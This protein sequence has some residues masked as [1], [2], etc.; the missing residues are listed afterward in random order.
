[1]ANTRI[2]TLEFLPEIFQT[3]TNA[4]FLSA[5][6]DQLVNPPIIQKIEGYIGSKLGYG[7]NAK[8][9]YVKEINKTR[10]DYQLDPGVVFTKN[11]ESVAQDFISYPG[12]LDAIK[13]EGGVV[14]NNNR[15]FESQF[16]SWDSFT[17]LDKLINY[18]QYY[19]IPNGPPSVTVAADVV[20][21]TND[22][23]V[24]DLSNGYNIR[25]V[26]ASGGSINPTLTLLRGGIYRFF[27]NQ[28]SQFWIQ[29]EPS[30]NGYSPTQTNL[31]VREVYGVANNGS[32][33]GIV[34]FV[35]PQKN[36]Q[37]EY[38]F[39]GN[40]LVD[41][42]STK[43]YSEINGQRLVDLVDIDGVTSL[44]GLTVM[45]YNT[46]ELDE[47]GFTQEFFDE[48]FYD[49]NGNLVLPQTITVT[50]TNVSNAITCN[51]TANLTVGQTI[52]FDGLSFGGL[53][54]YASTGTIYYVKTII[55]STQFTVSTELD[56][57]TVSLI[58]ASGTLI[59]N[60]NQG[61][62]EE[63]F[64][65][66]VNNFFYRVEYVGNPDNPV[67]KLVPVELIPT[68]EKI[69]AQYGTQWINRN[70]YK[71]IL[72]TISLMPYI[73]APLDTLYYQDG[74]N[75]NK[76]G[77]IRL[78]ESNFTNTLNVE[79]DILGKP[80]FTSTNGVVF[81][82]GLKVSFD[83]DVIPTS[84]LQG[85]YYVEG[86]GSAIELIPT[87]DLFCP[88]PFTEAEY[89]SYDA[90]PY[91]IGNYDGNLYIPVLQDYITIARNSISKNAWSR[92][93]RWFHIDVINATANY[94]NNPQIATTLATRQN[95]AKRPIIE[96]YPNLALFNTGTEGKKAIDFIDF[97]TTD[98]FSNVQGQVSYYPDVETY[99]TF[100]G[101]IN[102]VVTG[103]ST[104]ATIANNKIT[105]TFQVGQYITDT[106]VSNTDITYPTVLPP[107]ARITNIITNT[108]TTT[109]VIGWA[110]PI[111]I[112]TN[113][114]NVSFVAN[115]EQN[116]S[117]KVFDGSRI[118]FANDANPDVK[119]KIY[120]VNISQTETDLLP[121]ITLTEEPDAFC[122]PN[123]MTVVIRGFNYLGK[124][125]YFNG[126][127]WVVAQQKIYVNQPPLFDVFDQNYVSFG[128]EEVYQGTTFTGC[129]LFAYGILDGGVDDPILDFPI[130]YSNISNLGDIS[131]DVSINLDTFKYVSGTEP[132]TQKVNTGYVSN[133]SSRDSFVREIGWQTARGP[134]VQYQ[135]FSFDY[136]VE[137]PPTNYTCDISMLPY[138]GVWPTIQ[139]YI[140]NVFQPA[141][142]YNVTV[143]PKS[144]IVK[145]NTI[146]NINTVVQVLILS[147]QVS[148]TAYYQIPIN[149]SNNPFNDD[150]MIADLGDIR[151]HYQSIFY[152][153]L[154][155]VGE[156]FGANN[157]RDLGNVVPYGN[158]IIQNSASIVL[159]GAF[160][161]KQNHNLFDALLFNSREYT[162]FKALLINT[163]SN[164]NLPQQYNPSLVLD[165]ALDIISTSKNE[166]LAFFWSDMLPNKAP[167]ISN[168]Y[169]FNNTLSVSRFPLSR[170]Y[171]FDKANYYG[172]LV[173]LARVITGTVV[174]KQ[175]T[176]GVDYTV[177]G[178]TLIV[179]IP[180][181][182]NDKITVKEYNQTYG[183]YVPN[184]PTK[185][186]L[187]PSFIPEVVLDSNYYVPTW[188]IKGHDGSYNKLY[189]EY[190]QTLGTLVD[191]RDQALL[192]FE[193]RIYNN[194]KLSTTVPIE[195]YEVLPGYF[196]DSDYSNTEFL[197]I[198]SE[199]FLNWVGENRLNYQKQ[200]YN[201]YN[202][203]TYNYSDSQN[204]LNKEPIEQGYWRG[205]YQY[206]YDTT[207]P[208][209]TP[210]E[211]LGIVNEPTWWQE[212]YGPP[213]YSRDNLVL[214]QDLELG[215][216][217]NNGSP[218]IIPEVSRP[219]LLNV[220]P[221]DSSG[222]LLSP[223]AVIVAN[224]NANI[225]ER[226]WKVGDDG[227]VELSYRRS[228]T[229][230]FDL[231][232]ILALTKPAKFFNLGVDLDNYKYNSEFNQYLVNNRSHLVIDNIEIYGNG[233]PKTSYINWI[234]DYEK[235]L[236]LNATDN[237]K[238]LLFNL[239]VR[240]VYR[241]GGFSDKNLL[242][243]YVEKSNANS[244]DSSLLIPDESYSVLLY[245]N[246]P[247]D[248]IVYTAV[249]I[250]IVEGRYAVYGNSQFFTHFK[251]LPPIFDGY[252]ET[253][254]VEKAEV[255]V[256]KNYSETD[257]VII[258][259][260][261]VFETL[262]EVSQFLASY[263]AFLRS[264]GMIFDEVEY[265]LVVDWNLMIS[266]FLYW[267]Q[268]G[269]ESG[270]VITLNPSATVL[271]FDKE[272]TIVQ[273]LTISQ[274]NFLLNQNLY[275]IKLTDLN[276]LRDGTLFV[277]Q[278]LN[279][280]D[281]IAYGQFKISNIEHGIVFNNITE[282]NDVIYN[283]ITGLRQNRMYL[284][285]TKTAEWN[286]SVNAYGFILNQDN[287]TEWSKDVKYTKGQIV[288]YKNKY[289]TALSIIQPALVF[290]EDQWKQTDYEEIQKGLLPNSST[291][292]YESTL[293]YNCNEANL[294]KDA[295]LLSFSLIGYRPR[296]YLA[297]VDLTDIT[298][299]NVY[300][301]LIKNKG[302]KNAIEAFRGADLPQGGIDYEVY[303][304]WAIK[305]GEFGGTLNENFVE[306]RL[307]QS[308]LTGNPATVC[309]TNG[310]FEG[311]V[312]QQVPLYSLFNY[313]RPVDQPS[314]LSTIPASTP[315][316]VY[317][318]AGYVNFNDVKMSTYFYRNMKDAVDI[319]NIK[320][321]L[322]KFYVRDYAYIANFLQ[323]WQVFTLTTGGIV[324][325]VTQTTSTRSTVLF[326]EP[327][328]LEK[329]QPF[330]IINFNP[331]INGYYY[332]VEVIS[333]N[334]VAINLAFT[335]P[336]SPVIGYGIALLLESQ[337][338]TTPNQIND[339]IN[340]LS[341]EF[342]KNTV[343]VDE[344]KNGGWAVYRKSINYKFE[345]DFYEQSGVTFGSAVAYNNKF[346][347]LFADAGAGKVY[348]Y[349][350]NP[351]TQQYDQAT[352]ILTGE[353]SFGTSM[354]YADNLLFVSE[355]NS[356][357]PKVYIFVLNDT[358]LTD[359]FINY[360]PPIQSPVENLTNWGSALAVSTDTNWLYI[361][362]T[363]NNRVFVY[364]KQ[365]IDLPVTLV[366]PGITYTIKEVGNT[367]WEGIGAVVGKVGISF[368]ATDVG[369]GTGLVTQSGYQYSTVI[370]PPT[371]LFSNSNFGHAIS[372]NYYG[373][374]VVISAPNIDYSANI[375]NWGK[376]F[377]YQRGIQN[378]ESQVSV[379]VNTQ[380]L[381]ELAFNIPTV[382]I[383][384]TETNS[385]GNLLTCADT[386]ILQS[387]TPV[388][389]NGD[390]GLSGIV[391]NII[392]YINQII[393]STEFTIKTLRTSTT[394][395]NVNTATGLSINGV[396]QVTP[397][398]VTNNGVV[399][400]DN[401]Y[402]VVNNSLIY[403]GALTTGDIINVST[404]NFTL[405]QTL[406][407][408]STNT[409]GIQFGT[410]VD[411]NNQGTEV[412]VGSPFE[413]SD[414]NQ[415]GAAYRYTYS[416]ASYGMI[417]GTNPCNVLAE[418]TLLLNG[419]MVK[420][421]PGDA[422]SVANTIN[423]YGITNI[424]SSATSDNKL[425]IDIVNKNIALINKKLT[426][427][428]SDTSTLSEL[429]LQLFSNT[430]VILCPHKIGPTQFG[431]S[432]KFN[433][434]NSVVISAP[435]GT[436]FTG[437][438]FD[439]IDD[440]NLDKDTVFDNNATQFIDISPSA[441]AVYMFDYIQAYN[442][443]LYNTGSYVYAQST[444]NFNQVY[445]ESPYYG[446]ALEFNENRV[447]VGTPNFLPDD[448]DGQVVLYINSFGMQDW[449]IYRESAPIVDIN[450]V[451]NIQLFSANT[452]DTLINVD[453]FDPLQ[454]KLL[455]AV[456]Q[457]IDFVCNVD[458]AVY[459]NATLGQQPVGLT[460]G[461]KQEGRI[462][463]DT[464]NVRFVNYHQND[465]EYNARFWG[466][467]FPGSDVAMYTWTAS[468]VIPSV[469][470]SEGRPGTPFNIEFYT[471]ENSV[472]AAGL[473]VQTYYFWV[474]NSKVV[475]KKIGKTLSDSTLE[476][477]IKN[478]KNSGISYFAPIY[479]DAY[480]LYNIGSYLNANDTVLHIGYSTG[481]TD[482]VAQ[483][484][485]TLIRADYADDFLPG[486][487]N[488][489][490]IPGLF[491]TDIIPESLYD[492]LL[493][494][495][496][497]TD[498][499]GQVVPNPWLPKAV[500][501]G[502]LARP[503]Q[504][505]FYNRLNAIKNYL[506]YANEIL[507]QYPI[508]E[509]RR[510][511]SFLFAKNPTIVE[512]IFAGNCQAGS[513]YTITKVGDVD[514]TQIGAPSN[515]IGIGFIATGPA[516]GEF[517][518][519]GEASFLAF[520]EG[521]LYDTQDYWEYIT[522]WAE[523][524]NNSTK[525]ILQVTAYAD[526][527]TLNVAIGS[528]VT[529]AENGDG[530]FEVYRYDGNDIWTRIGLQQGTIQFKLYLWDYAAGKLG[531]GDNFFDTSVYDLYPSEETRYIVRALS[532]QIYINELL[533]HRNK[534]LILL[535]QYIQSETIESQN[536]IPWLNKTS[537]VDVS[538]TIRELRPVEVFQSDNQKFLEGYINEVKPY[539]VLIK[540]FIFKYTGEEI[541][542]VEP[543]DFDLPATYDN[544]TRQ[545]ITPQLSYLQTSDNQY[546]PDSNIWL[547]S[548]YNQ[549]FINK[550]VSINGGQE[551]QIT[552]LASYMT[553][554][555]TFLFVDNANGF[556]INGT[557]RIG[558]ELITYSFVDTSLNL[559]GGLYRGY[560]NTPIS[561]HIPGEVVFINLPSVL[562]L[563]G[564]RAYV[565]PPRII[566]YVNPNNTKT[567]EFTGFIEGSKLTVTAV[568]SGNIIVGNY[569]F[570]QNVT[571][572]TQ[573]ISKNEDGTYEISVPQNLTIQ[574]FIQYLGPTREAQ[575]QAVMNID[576]VSE[577]IV[578][579]PGQGYMSTP[580]IRIEPSLIVVFTSNDILTESS[581]IRIYAPNLQTGD[582]V[583][584]QK[585]NFGTNVGG[586][587]NEQW[588][589]IN[590]LQ[591]TPTTIIA[592]YTSY[593]DAVNNFNRVQIYSDGTGNDHQLK[594]TAKA[595][596]IVSASPI[597]ENNIK[598]RYDRTTYN[599]Q[600]IEWEA[601]QY[602]GSFFAGSYSNSEEVSSS[603]I[604]LQSTQPPIDRILASAQGV[605]FEIESVSNDREIIWSTFVRT[606]NSTIASSNAVK[607]TV[608]DT[609]VDENSSGST[610]G[611]YIGMPVKF[612]G[613][614]PLPIIAN[615]VYYVHSI[616]NETEFTISATQF[617]A[618]L[619]GFN[620]IT[621]LSPGASVLTAQIVDTA[622]LTVNYPGILTVTNTTSTGNKLTVPVSAIGTGGTNNFY[623]GL[624]I[625]FTQGG[626]GNIVE[627]YTYYV[628][629]VIDNQNFTI[630]DNEVWSKPITQNPYVITA[631]ETDA[632]VD[633]VTVNSTAYLSLNDPIIFSGETFGGIT[634]GELYYVAQVVSITEIKISNAINGTILPLT[635]DTGSCLLI[636]QVT[637][638]NV[639]TST[640]NMV[641]N[642]ALPVSPGQVD[643][644][645]F[646]LY[647]T[648]QQYPDVDYGIIEN[649][650]NRDL[651][652]T[653]Y[654]D[655]I[656]ITTNSGGTDNFYV[657]MPIRFVTPPAGSGLSSGITYYVK[658]FTGQEDSL[659][660]GTY[661]PGLQVTVT[662]TDSSYDNLICSS[663][664]NDLYLN[665]P[666]IFSGQSLGNIVLTEEYFVRYFV[667]TAGSFTIGK[668]YIIE[669]QG[670]TD[671]TLIGAADNN[672]GTS[673]VA[674]GIGTGSGT[675]YG[676]Y[677]MLNGNKFKLSV[678][679]SGPILTLTT[680]NGSMT[681][682]GSPY[683]SVSLT[684]GGAIE[685]L[686]YAKADFTLAQFPSSSESPPDPPVFDISYILGGYRAIISYGGEGFA[687]GNTIK[688]LGALLGGT[689][690]TNNLTLTVNNV[691]SNGTITELIC[692]G[693]PPGA[694]NNY[695]L[696]VISLNQFE[697][698]S[699]PLMQ[700]PVS[701]INF[702]YVG[703]TTTTTSATGA[704]NT[705]IVQDTSNFEVN[706][707]VVF[708]GNSLPSELTLGQTYYILAIPSSTTIT[709]AS[710][711]QDT[712][713]TIASGQ[714]ID[715]TMA[716]AGSFALLPEPFYFN[717]SI[718]KFNNRVYICVIS[719]NDTEFIFGKWELL[720]PADR[721][722]N[723]MDRV[724]GYYA[725][726]VNM[727]GVDLT[728][729]FTGVT[730]PNITYL[731]NPF[732]PGQQFTLD[733]VLKGDQFYPT[734]IAIVSLVHNGT[735]YV[736]IANEPTYSLVLGSVTGDTWSMAKLSNVPI[737]LTDITY[738]NL[739]GADGELYVVT[740]TNSATP[741]IKSAD[742]INWSTEAY[743]APDLTPLNSVA[744]Y[745]NRIIYH[746]SRWIAVG[747]NI[748]T[749]EKASKAFVWTQ[750]YNFGTTLYNELFDIVYCQLV[751]GSE[752]TFDG[753]IAVGK[754][755]ELYSGSTINTN[756]VLVSSNGNSWSRN[757]A[758]TNSGLL[759]ICTNN[760]IA[761]AVGENGVIYYTNNSVNWTGIR[762]AS[763]IS[764]NADI[765]F[766]VTS[767][768]ANLQVNDEVRFTNSFDVLVANT[769][770]FVHTVISQT[771]IKLKDNLGNLISLSGAGAIPNQ[772]FMYKYPQLPNLNK[773]V[774]QN[775]LFMA[776]GNDGAILT[777]SDAITWVER[778]SDT[779]HNLYNVI[780]L[781]STSTW[782]VVGDDDTIIKSEDNGVTWENASTLTIAPN[783]YEIEG[784]P[785]SYGYG[786]EEL[787]P[788]NVTDNLQMIVTTRPGTNWP[789]TTYAHT[790]YNIVSYEIQ[791]TG[792]SQTVYSWAGDVLVPAQLSVFV[793][794]GTSGLSTTLYNGI[795]FS[796]NWLNRTI[797]LFTP[798]A[799]SPV[800]DTLR[801][802]V[803]EIGNGDQLVKSNTEID[804]IRNNSITGFS[805]I[806][807]NCNY[808]DILVNGSG[809][810]RPN[811]GAFEIFA[812]ETI[813]LTNSIICD[814]VTNL[815]ANSPIK[816]QGLTFGNI[817]E[818]TT[819]Y[820]KSISVF[821]SSIVVSASINSGIAGPTFELVDATGIMALVV[822]A[823]TGQVWSDPYVALDGTKLVLGKTNNVIRTKSGTNTITTNSTGGITV[824]SPIVFSDTMFGG[825]IIPQTVYYVKT[826]V[827]NN[828]FT[829]SA[830]LGGSTLT[831]T[832]A[833]GGATFITN[834]F[835]F[836]EI[837]NS[838]QAKII[839][840]ENYNNNTDYIVYSI[841]GETQPDQYGYSILETEVFQGDG[842]QPVFNLGNYIDNTNILNAIVEVNGVRQ[843]YAK[844]DI[845]LINDTI[846]FIDPP[847]V[848][849][850]V[851]VSTYNLTQRQY[852]NTDF[853]I[854]GRP[855]SEF[856]SITVE[857]TNHNEVPY[858][859]ILIDAGS[860]S[861]GETY[862][863]AYIND[864]NDPPGANTDF[865]TI[866]AVS[867]NAGSLVNGETYIIYFVGTTDFTLA[868]APANTI[869]TKFTADFVGSDPTLGTGTVY[870][871]NF[872]ATGAGTGTGSAVLEGYGF[873]ST[874]VTAGDFIIGQTYVIKSV[875][876]TDFTLVGA[877]SNTVG[878]S[879]VATGYGT[880]TGTAY[881]PGY[882][883][884]NTNW[885]T[886]A[887]GFTTSGLN[888]GDPIVFAA[889][890]LDGIAPGVTYY[891]IEIWN[892][893]DFVISTQIA[894]EALELTDDTGAMIG[895]V[896]GLTVA[897]IINIDNNI[898]GP[899]AT[900]YATA[901]I[902]TTG[903]VAGSFVV[904]KSYV[905]SSIGTTDFTLIGAAS[906]TVGLSFKAT[907]I[908]SG[909]GTVD[910]YELEVDSTSGFVNGQTV[911][912][913]G[914]SIGGVETNGTVYFVYSFTTG[915]AP[916]YLTICDENNNIISVS[917]DT[918]NMYTIVGGNPAVRIT[919]GIP[920][921]LLTN[922]E[923][924][925]DGCSGSVQLNGQVF[926][927]HKI[928]TSQ[929]DLYT[930]PF[931]SAIGGAN[932][933]VTEISSYTGGGYIW[934]DQTFVISATSVFGTD[935]STNIINVMSYE[936][937]IINT[938][939]IFTEVNV[940]TGDEIFTSSNIIA[941]TTYYVQELTSSLVSAGSFIVGRAYTIESVGS[942]NFINVGAVSN[943]IGVSFIATG[944]GS[945]SGN[946]RAYGVKISEERNGSTLVLGTT[947]ATSGSAAKLSQWD[948]YNVDRLWVTVDG[949][950]V[951]SSKL[952]LYGNNNL[953][954]LTTIESGQEVIITSMIPSSTPDQEVYMLNVNQNQEAN[955]YRANTLTKTWLTEPLF[956][957]DE[958]IYVDDV[959]KLTNS[960][961]QN[962]T[963]PA[964]VVA[965]GTYKIGLEG[966]K[967][968]I[969][970]IKVY[971]NNPSRLG[972]LNSNT[973]KI[974]IEDLSPILVIY[975]GLYVQTG[976]N[977]TITI[978]EGELIVINGEQIL[979]GTVNST[980]NSLG[981]LQRGA[982]NTGIQPYVPVYTTVYSKLSANK[983]SEIDY[984]K[985]WNSE[986]YNT[987]EGD[988]LQISVTESAQFLHTDIT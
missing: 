882:F 972:Y 629:T 613:T 156:V 246:Q 847:P 422:T 870:E 223:F 279:Q 451:N 825:V 36:A 409:V 628:V 204:K 867:V 98:A 189:G 853:G 385:D 639:T 762:Q 742:G 191:F 792:L 194:L 457:N 496:S 732:E 332:V 546:L 703:F 453:Y 178:N 733:T 946:A 852:L 635:S 510:E 226:S 539:H 641:M 695:Y 482:D 168:T 535:F 725:P 363:V 806:Y 561:N 549:W 756:L 472:N 364:R 54:A 927:V 415:E 633:T 421:Q 244:N 741:I 548:T 857:S 923:A 282:F 348:R 148:K 876:T 557:I 726:T 195:S 475:Y 481:N 881:G 449:E 47:Q 632:S 970:E 458:P 893:Q 705:I 661:F 101:T 1:M 465:V 977:L 180:L 944:I 591:T 590:L 193:T 431:H 708:T 920:H 425:I 202:E 336:A 583:Q 448:K 341:A 829:I 395:F 214:W 403:N 274:S 576:Q 375:N 290:N 865:G 778:N 301:N 802:D 623:I 737:G 680:S 643:G 144:T 720:D 122:L 467:I 638:F 305:S 710:N 779:V 592:L 233:I 430:Q 873:D 929:L 508:S 744:F 419:Y 342:T 392:Y 622:V 229:W 9:Q 960:I 268:I 934:L 248:L 287:I 163:V 345:K 259:Y 97:R 586:L 254:K 134:S 298:Q 843:T 736:A 699:D 119:N 115:D 763:V 495:M 174:T 71:N 791:P 466:T 519:T 299:I 135:V 696:K 328:N 65:D 357:N 931:T 614:I 771:Q 844:Y 153:N 261:Y 849:S 747:K 953:G 491:G 184:T 432:I 662:S 694:A 935:A 107:D 758:F 921:N 110:G 484:E 284:R 607:L 91:D 670:T 794:N 979:F 904:G 186:G 477:Y 717:Q 19:W 253:I 499:V 588:Y 598:L 57:T 563:N 358:V 827:D 874:L 902:A 264:K 371:L 951:P 83:G 759:S 486:L 968:M 82:N 922:S 218:V 831:L 325:Q 501:S 540:E 506:I 241:V 200:F 175:L 645:L 339:N 164:S 652:S 503:R 894:G 350:K 746:N 252:Y 60:I 397:L 387:N 527:S 642:V 75:P 631:T 739:G 368:I 40:N 945:G 871:I 610:I 323:N 317:Q 152:N 296:D 462:W 24:T 875:G 308:K 714:T 381:F 87:T 172:L 198:Y 120:L 177:D 879:F 334:E 111:T 294:E 952:R 407:S 689:T 100:N 208:H 716:K 88:E 685:D 682:T 772:T 718:V 551:I 692:S 861:L 318:D 4:Q 42:I 585:G 469:Y 160:L 906:N 975:D 888:I 723:A 390:F 360:Q 258:P 976:D 35:V 936:N 276:V 928:S 85:E 159:P 887:P 439:F 423:S 201:A 570:N 961:V 45:F 211:M 706:D 817:V 216:N 524:Y 293:Y 903:I 81:T 374:T 751:V 155:S 801:I 761:V 337:R 740:S 321:P 62:Y 597:R 514:W 331:N 755:Q 239:D 515:E 842:S 275:P 440:E 651:K 856:I 620:N 147:K 343:W 917:T 987:T 804:P 455:G 92:S 505:F 954:I 559:I 656:A 750:R 376:T 173:Y 380:Q 58:T 807:L 612:E 29:T 919:T 605:A 291:R 355:P 760:A 105:G 292:S 95:K 370:T 104:N 270:S 228:S 582:L 677:P 636:S 826:I 615:T 822:N 872:T 757:S 437:T 44:N 398:S 347:Y 886:C 80:N 310:Y 851:A 512:I 114:T 498:E 102:A 410:S 581:T 394:S 625:F 307:N 724:I 32:D 41:V 389:F 404:N 487:P 206:F 603:S 534:S 344:A 783:V 655:K 602:Y 260:G 464:S 242:K 157:Y 948:Q 450:R 78:I 816:F 232:R 543:T 454:G 630:S 162:K 719:N 646:T 182:P 700:V 221:T 698:Y 117:Y 203:F 538:H 3:P 647:Q 366:E 531:F 815:V 782:T 256:A 373:D 525:S 963:T 352:Q 681:G 140:N 712:V 300:K 608:S 283:L 659:N 210:W 691:N 795:D 351:K 650:I 433:E 823:G 90:L 770:Y 130:R 25:T 914:T 697:V 485:Y 950:R 832:N 443:N 190:N 526:L 340:L 909:T 169:N 59:G 978:T 511:A 281:T 606:V 910:L 949:Y 507:K 257:E 674:T 793:I 192:E 365:N 123:D 161:R 785:F 207:T 151:Q 774:Y 594:L 775:S 958:F 471:S 251:I 969:C 6:L 435:V 129:K 165:E 324:V 854:T 799:F 52:T 522:W 302:T 541:N 38:N 959:S 37:D 658:E 828:E 362:D 473:I 335:N 402:A 956:E 188:F 863:I 665:M 701:G 669:Q 575:L 905:I 231:M 461:A 185:L 67:L 523:G 660:P 690:P 986:I 819:Y 49:T 738:N 916:V 899:L 319:N 985:T 436:R 609:S 109:L 925:I 460:W 966:D 359:E 367:N 564:G 784:A 30:V 808:S 521:E 560:N 64:Y 176:K 947:T 800:S 106:R 285:G 840:A 911:Q 255:K 982:N 715:G 382:T 405:V 707:A 309:L 673:F 277:A 76:V 513:Y 529:V 488:N 672:P 883:D 225:F 438:Q 569:I 445:G 22:Y 330:V 84:Y 709:I 727:P 895:T 219:G 262:Q 939:V 764:V 890:T 913:R 838:T 7:I 442:E 517:R 113:V 769:S 754:A 693:T 369:T 139:V 316:S 240:L 530:K 600:V 550:G 884:E 250:Q 900:T 776:V 859:G 667:T 932:Y 621:P 618:Q 149:L 14:D 604:Q 810:I 896:N 133:Y 729:L 731:G 303:E 624:P 805:E 39:P 803:Y 31:Y 103:T 48:N 735:N 378:F 263:G 313:Q 973:Y 227:P 243:F 463:F 766:L 43:P 132:I 322:Q 790:G 516:T 730:Y 901:T 8:D 675:A 955:V 273:P 824:N 734:D 528:I 393:N 269:W 306:F 479:P 118:V 836:A 821:D 835:A 552:S 444:N 797:T 289:W 765:N 53:N 579:D 245:E 532:E 657:N 197:Q 20:Y 224:Y 51:S 388:I 930:S 713:I 577:V 116:D 676:E 773:V 361:S 304:N 333:L 880:G 547:T 478:P 664:T 584:Y 518:N 426:I 238:S 476:S 862:A 131:F 417:M 666:I 834:D 490:N 27:V 28:T 346:K 988:P 96:F 789:V 565:E 558:R 580:E 745:L 266:E 850:T 814:D 93:N 312:Q 320:V 749:S 578:V 964:L 926:Y 2:R 50:N 542:V 571:Y 128:N 837:T 34:E 684:P 668:T 196:R 349:D 79:T 489:R 962:V 353:T 429:G 314:I 891:I 399:V 55:D 474:R 885:L 230:P 459:L 124:T 126:A 587:V 556:P 401:Y 752:I 848:N 414:E 141:S 957:L 220:I 777:S 545:F 295:D 154:N 688:I 898:T 411:I 649:L 68:L 326:L 788:G 446:Y 599:S 566:A 400:S 74:S 634:A 748:I 924:R 640:G 23:L 596:A 384:I 17:N 297:L 864:D 21:A 77:V 780:Y 237:V 329:F 377:I 356:L 396:C 418:R 247:F 869:G 846:T 288:K 589:Y 413:L 965:S 18:N 767:A 509:I 918:G 627:N 943:T 980:N 267:A 205:L 199:S 687:I 812:T 753:Y 183:S 170:V 215:L 593:S 420:L 66:L 136:F 572:G 858:D 73:T 15:L 99:T 940:N 456:R 222:N 728:Q 63:G 12:I 150:L 868:G 619:T 69:T 235:Q 787:V 13:L 942:T 311:K 391:P 497:G 820:I 187:Y 70:F 567:A 860:F 315:V 574:N 338:V 434:F 897:N 562:V 167:Y 278:P 408:N 33:Q 213:P 428:V 781:A 137:T 142:N 595:T 889:P 470:V 653:L 555:S 654:S 265:G 272:N 907:G 845:S 616:I 841:F 702:D 617:G 786:P 145:L 974:V 494:S 493:D 721:R 212:R 809:A 967:N 406:T 502:V 866:G 143:T 327:H 644:Q 249:V 127:N 179:N 11:D 504:S 648:S 468:N 537:L 412:L 722:L 912:F 209:L 171:D 671:F 937:L 811:T 941:G 818:D 61:L 354:V 536:F 146:I 158:K 855:G 236:G 427:G 386:S 108:T 26:G 166:S 452:N 877:A 16:Y 379:T 234:V 971:N 704:S 544:A 553:Q 981:S 533:I 833:T 500:Q 683:L 679:I 483:N 480:A 271:E 89:I 983:L 686:S 878:V 892:L 10:T 798:I 796:I 573:I 280:G 424:I 663:T 121:V 768:I 441:G 383:E 711:P 286:G 984:S 46:G 839:F 601:G 830:T 125:V 94:N 568:T 447:I 938:P 933:P 416:S 520:N 5:T 626:F 138:D 743:L 492:R 372:T 908:G 554:K 181:Q 915:I 112:P 611:F 56:G 678:S 86:V 72:G 813:Q 637:T 217:Y